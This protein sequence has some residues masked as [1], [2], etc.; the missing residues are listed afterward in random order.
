MSKGLSNQKLAQRAEMQ[1][2]QVN[3]YINNDVALLRVDVLARIC[4]VLE[5]DI[6]DLLEFKQKE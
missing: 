4:T 1:L 6:S 2:T 5:C 3:K